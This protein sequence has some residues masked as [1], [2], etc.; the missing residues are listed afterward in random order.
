MI[1]L[2]QNVI[3]I[4]DNCHILVM[5]S[6]KMVMNK[7][8]YEVFDLFDNYNYSADNNVS[9]WKGTINKWV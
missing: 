6:P 9:G 3:I 4:K 1:G 2:I 7:Q 8:H 5:V